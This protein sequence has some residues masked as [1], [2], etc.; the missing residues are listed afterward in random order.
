MRKRT[1]LVGFEFG[2]WKHVQY[3]AEFLDNALDAIETFQ[4]SELKKE[5]SNL[6]FTLDKE[7]FLENLTV[8]QK[9]K[10][11]EKSQP[12]NEEAKKALLEELRPTKL[13]ETEE[14]ETKNLSKPDA[15]IVKE[16]I[17]IELEVKKIIRDLES[18]IK[19]VEHAEIID[20]EPLVLIRLTETEAHSIL[21]GELD[22]K[23]IMSYKFEVFDNGLGM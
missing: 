2:Y 12:L 9:E 1:Q 21:T 10:E 4:W 16:E 19:P 7:I 8:L 13:E 22:A 15:D 5:E 6:K 23:N 20:K 18:L 11:E 14:E 17:E 3:C